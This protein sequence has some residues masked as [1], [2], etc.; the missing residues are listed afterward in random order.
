MQPEINEGFRLS[1]QQ[2]N[3]WNLLHKNPDKYRGQASLLIK[4]NLDQ[5]LLELLLADSLR[6][7]EILHTTFQQIP[8]LSVPLQILNEHTH[9]E[10][11]LF[12]T[13]GQAQYENAIN[14][15]LASFHQELDLTHGPLWHAS[16]LEIAPQCYLFT[17]TIHALCADV[18]TLHL[19]L[20]EISQRYIAT[21]AHHNAHKQEDPVQYIDFSEWQNDF[22]EGLD[23]NA[24]IKKSAL[25]AAQRAL[26]LHSRFEQVGKDSF[27]PAVLDL[28]IDTPLEKAIKTHLQTYHCTMPGFLLTCWYLLQRRLTDTT[29]VAIGVSCSSRFRQGLEHMLGP[30]TMDLPL[31]CHIED[32]Q[33]FSTLLQTV[34]QRLR[35]LPE[36]LEY[37]DWDTLRAEL[38]NE[39]AIPLFFPVCF[40]FYDTPN[41][42]IANNTTTFTVEQHY[43]CIDRF[44]VKLACTYRQHQLIASLHYDNTYFSESA[45]AQML[46]YFHILVQNASLSLEEQAGHIKIIDEQLYR[47]LIYGF[48]APV[49]N[50]N[51]PCVHQ[52]FTQ[53][54]AK[55][56]DHYAVVYEEEVI[57]YAEL[58]TR[59][60]QLAHYLHKCNVGPEVIVALG[61][62]RSVE[63]I[64]GILGILKAG[65]A[66]VPLDPSLPQ[67]RLAFMLKESQSHFLL[68]QADVVARYPD[69]NLQIILLDQDWANV[70]LEPKSPP[71]DTVQPQNAAYVIFTSGSTGKPKGVLVEHQHLASYVS[72][73][74]ERLHLDASIKNFALI[75]SPGTDLA[76]TSLYPCLCSGRSLHLISQERASHPEA[77]AEYQRQHPIDVLKITPSHLLALLTASQPADSIPRKYLI[78][79]GEATSW[80]LARTLQTLAPHCTLINHYGPTETTIGTITYQVERGTSPQKNGTLPLGRPLNGTRVYILDR[81]QQPVPPLVT[82]ELYISGVQVS[83]GYLY[84]EDL[85]K[86]R[87]LPDP[88]H[89]HQRMYKTGDTGYYRSD[90]MIEFSGRV[91]NQIKIRG[92]RV[93]PEEIEVALEQIPSISKA[94]IIAQKTSSDDQQLIAYLVASR[95]DTMLPSN[96]SITDHLKALFPDYMIPVDFIRI[97]ALPLTQGGKV[98]RQKLIMSPRT[99]PQE[100]VVPP[101]DLVELQL[102]Q[103][104]EE[105][106]HI[107]P[108]GVT[109]NFFHLGGHSLLAVRLLVEI[110][111]QFGER[112]SLSDLIQAPTIEQI[113]QQ[114]HQGTS[115]LPSSPV[116]KIQTQG[117][118]SPFFCIHP[119]G[120]NVFCYLDL[121]QALGTT[122][123][124]YGIQAVGI[125][126]KQELFTQIET[127]AHYYIEAMRSIQPDGPYLLGGWS[128]GGVIAF[129]MARQLQQQNQS[130]AFLAVLDSQIPSVAHAPTEHGDGAFVQQFIVDLQRLLNIPADPAIPEHTDPEDRLQMLLE[131]G[132]SIHA[133]APDTSFEQLT[134]LLKVFKTNVHALNTYQPHTY[135]G[136]VSLFLADEEKQRDTLISTW[137]TLAQDG[138]TVQTTPGDHYTLLGKT[139]VHFLAQQLNALIDASALSEKPA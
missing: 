98:D 28:A 68:T 129:E 75:S 135:A 32:E 50:I 128:M 52:T 26:A 85:T 74:L 56:P 100:V 132:R 139:H 93:E 63:M 66:Y 77:F 18:A 42:T 86:E 117:Q 80:D 17:L 57:T 27:N 34:E 3:I 116:V 76:Y 41:E 125:D 84:H 92:F 51:R 1:L 133:F 40:D 131:Q 13:Y 115:T 70:A 138:L 112:L 25:T 94:V 123:P 61:T 31:L 91:D 22:V 59:S 33:P 95:Q 44:K 2:K 73:F 101:H 24:E 90:G 20:Q 109:N 122:R 114:L 65:G 7:Y 119:G 46:H 8:G 53:Q 15:S 127:M 11:L 54:A 137:E 9:H 16:L 88:F 81:Y 106:L 58:D 69:D 64:V 118:K 30:L 6:K 103:I 121:A 49:V 47:Q 38:N 45:I 5:E 48:N 23:K 110:E 120:G 39:E 19:L 14:I 10:A 78:L 83:R 108:I 72:S 4:G 130:T 111:K 79:G 124:F 37:F 104:W 43:A 36:Q 96:Q 105:L 113:G 55:T 89:P 99:Q 107:H 126:G 82:G 60:N 87:F 35:E 21:D 67:K 134:H 12:K 102:I 71:P 136:T 62:R 29:D 97:D